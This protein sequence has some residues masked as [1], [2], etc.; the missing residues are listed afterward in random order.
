MLDPGD[1]VRAGPCRQEVLVD[2]EV[3]LAK[4]PHAPGQ[5][6]VLSGLPALHGWHI[7][8]LRERPPSQQHDLEYLCLQAVPLS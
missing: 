8:S 4:A 1:D 7:P 3:L 2:L 6:R 5:Q